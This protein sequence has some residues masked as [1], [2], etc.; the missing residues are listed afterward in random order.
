MFLFLSWGW[1]NSKFSRVRSEGGGRQISNFSLIQKSP[2]HPG[3]GGG[4]E[5]CG[6]FPLFGTCFN[7][8]ASLTKLELE[9]S[10]TDLQYYL[11]VISYYH[12][13]L[14]RLYDNI[15]QTWFGANC[16]KESV[17]KSFLWTQIIHTLL[18][19]IG[20]NQRKYSKI[21]RF[22]FSLIQAC[23]VLP[24]WLSWT[25]ALPNN[26]G[27]SI[28]W[29]Y[30]LLPCQEPPPSPPLCRHTPH[31]SQWLWQCPSRPCSLRWPHAQ[32]DVPVW[33]GRSCSGS[34]LTGRQQSQHWQI[35]WSTHLPSSLAWT[36]R[37]L[38]W[39]MNFYFCVWD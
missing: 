16:I 33:R 19:L 35:I 18:Y 10:G 28:C 26:L 12:L 23:S 38:L 6:L 15:M 11:S 22:W 14:S 7:L 29:Q 27:H 34:G 37:K 4:Q 17:A 9:S 31:R 25:S 2:K 24:H 13:I 5:N 32:L 39:G 3:G 30:L 8:M 21:Y 36:L 20:H 1:Q